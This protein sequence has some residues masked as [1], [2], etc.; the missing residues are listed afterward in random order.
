MGVGEKVADRGF[1]S[2]A[3]GSKRSHEKLR[4]L[5]TPLPPRFGLPDWDHLVRGGAQLPGS[6]H[7]WAV[8]PFPGRRDSRDRCEADRLRRPRGMR[9][10]PLRGTGSESER[11]ACPGGL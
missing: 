2:N 7:F 10:M 8:R 5:W 9:D 1:F 6:A 4:R 3:A 11:K